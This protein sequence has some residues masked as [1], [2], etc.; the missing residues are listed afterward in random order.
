MRDDKLVL[1]NSDLHRRI[2]I[3]CAM[4]GISIK[5]W[6]ESVL[7]DALDRRLVDSREEYITKGEDNA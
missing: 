1:V 4:A 6:V 7:T 3:R 5:D 2:K